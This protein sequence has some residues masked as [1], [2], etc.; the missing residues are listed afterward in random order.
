MQKTT[1]KLTLQERKKVLAGVYTARCEIEA[2][3][4]LAGQAKNLN[5][6]ITPWACWYE[7]S[8]PAHLVILLYVMGF[9]D[10]LREIVASDDQRKGFLKLAFDFVDIDDEDLE[11][12]QR[13]YPDEERPLLVSLVMALIGQINAVSQYSVPMSVLVAK[14][15]QGDHDALF[16]AVTIDRA[17]VSAEPI[18][19]Q[20]CLAQVVGDESFMNRLAKAVTRTKPAR[21]NSALDDFRYVLEAVVE[22]IGIDEFTN[23]ELEMILKEE[24][25]LYDND[26]DYSRR[27]FNKLIRKRREMVGTPN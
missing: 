1:K 4:E 13:D 20:I 26:S 9:E 7:C 17:A 3:P 5:E 22:G 2:L 16:R 8:M 21:P 19:K 14:A 10:R 24:L 18:A 6:L 27:A 11:E 23:T 25:E 15:G 12:L